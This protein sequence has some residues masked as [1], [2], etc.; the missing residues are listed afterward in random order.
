MRQTKKSKH[1]GRTVLIVLLAL[2]LLCIYCF[3]SVKNFDKAYDKKSTVYFDVT[4]P[5]GASTTRIGNI[6]QENEI[7]SSSLIFKIKSRLNNLDGSFQAG[8]YR[9]SPSMTMTDIME[10]LQH[11]KAIEVKI[12]IKEGWTMMQI[13]DYLAA[14]KFV[15]SKEDFYKACEDEYDYDFLPANGNKINDEVS[16]KAN[17]LEG[18]LY[19][20]TYFIIEG[21]NAHTIIDTLLSEFNEKAYNVYKDS[22]PAGYTFHDIIKLASVVEKEC[23]VDEERA[24]IAGV[25]WNRLDIGMKFESNAT[26]QY[27]TGD[28]IRDYDSPYNT[29]LNKGLPAGPICTPTTKTIDATINPEKHNYIYFCLKGDGTHTSNFAETY[30]EHL[31]NVEIW[32]NNPYEY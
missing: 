29:Y 11:A 17:R 25:F 31:K 28:F 6:L 27:V 18:Y 15:S 12:T 20:N 13:A 23:G 9:L 30:A 26:I 8:E 14:N 3:F 2:V 19:P 24:R 5:E 4:I 16:A 10:T 32:K 22:I 1:I 7:I 21:S